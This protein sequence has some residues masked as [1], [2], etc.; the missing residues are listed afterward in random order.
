M[1]KELLCAKSKYFHAALKGAFKEV[2]L[3]EIELEEENSTLFQIF[4]TWM[5][6]G[7]LVLPADI[8]ECVSWDDPETSDCGGCR[9]D[10][11]LNSVSAH[12]HRSK[13]HNEH[14]YWVIRIYILADRYDVVQLR[15][16]CMDA[17]L[18]ELKALSL[19]D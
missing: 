9:D 15:D 1:N 12:W 6:T 18:W 16:A 4:Y 14:I 7:K 5:Y 10:Q 17:I 11:T 2:T 8:P 13:L 19:L 3:W